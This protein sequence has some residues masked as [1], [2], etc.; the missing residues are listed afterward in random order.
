M[1]STSY[2]EYDSTSVEEAIVCESDIAT[3]PAPTPAELMMTVIQSK[4]GGEQRS[5]LEL[6]VGFRP[7]T[8]AGVATKPRAIAAQIAPPIIT[9]GVFLNWAKKEGYLL[10]P[11]LDYVTQ[12]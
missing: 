4:L 11:L 7:T 12:S 2:R 6:Y 5:V 10:A 1:N 9:T 3:C 8:A